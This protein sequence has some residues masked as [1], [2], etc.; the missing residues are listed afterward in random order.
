MTKAIFCALL[1]TL[2][3]ALLSQTYLSFGSGLSLQTLSSGDLNRFRASYDRV[4]APHLAR[5]LQGFDGP[6]G[7]RWELGLRK[8]GTRSMAFILAAQSWSSQDLAEFSNGARRTLLLSFSRLTAETE[9]GLGTGNHFINALVVFSFNRRMR[10]ESRYK[11]NPPDKLEKRL[12]GTYDS[13]AGQAIDI[14]LSAGYLREPLLLILRMTLPV[15]TSGSDSF[16]IDQTKGPEHDDFRTF[17]ADYHNFA[18]G[19]PYAGIR[20]NIDGF[21]ITLMAAFVLPF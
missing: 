13:L 19:L 21:K 3:S 8:I 1:L 11:G 14:G 6:V 10:I 15:V 18:S 5:G 12:S 9:Y 17:P 4:N 2:P 7:L 16:L 20:S